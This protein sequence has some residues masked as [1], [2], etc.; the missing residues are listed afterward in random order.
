MRRGIGMAELAP[1]WFW[2]SWRN[3]CGGSLGAVGDIPRNAGVVLKTK[4]KSK[5]TQKS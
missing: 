3:W 5:N 4:V 2:R 1:G